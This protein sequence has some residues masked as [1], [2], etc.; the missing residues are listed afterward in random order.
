[1][2]SFVSDLVLVQVARPRT[3]PRTLLG[4]NRISDRYEPWLHTDDVREM[5]DHCFS[6]FF[7]SIIFNRI[8]IIIDLF[9]VVNIVYP[10]GL[11]AVLE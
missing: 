11:T 6:L 5:T 2:R 10:R 8:R 7:L 4:T 9:L 1:M 3:T